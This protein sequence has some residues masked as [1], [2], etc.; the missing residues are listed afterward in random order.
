M[1][2]YFGLFVAVSDE[3][4]IYKFLFCFRFTLKMEQRHLLH[5]TVY[6]SAV[7]ACG[8]FLAVG[9]NFGDVSVLDFNLKSLSSSKPKLINCFS[10]HIGPVY[11][12]LGINNTLI[13]AGLGPVLIWNWKDIVSFDPKPVHKLEACGPKA[14]ITCLC[15]DKKHGLL[16]AGIEDSSIMIW[17][18]SNLSCCKKLTGHTQ[19]IH[20]I[21]LLSDSLASASEDGLVKIWD[22]HNNKCTKTIKPSNWNELKRPSLGSWIGCVASDSSTE[23]IVLGG[24]PAPALWHTRST[25]MAL[26]LN[27]SNEAQSFIPFTLHFYGDEIVGG[28]NDSMLHRWT[29]NGEQKAAVPCAISNIFSINFASENS[30]PAILTGTGHKIQLFTN[31]GYEGPCISL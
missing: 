28:G 18:L 3:T 31:L 5:C 19:Y 10:A 7:S 14:S 26:P 27:S 12:L 4:N 15:Y 20:D 8:E 29:S 9:N 13:S 23:W 6:S 2:G 11:A 1:G 22:T 21:C 25:S 16:F 30:L 24:G 17:D